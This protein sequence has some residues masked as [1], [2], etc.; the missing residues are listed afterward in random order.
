ML[1]GRSGW[2]TLDVFSFTTIVIAEFIA[3]QIVWLVCS[4]HPGPIFRPSARGLFAEL[5]APLLA[6]PGDQC[7]LDLV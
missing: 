2:T 3:R 4:F 5:L 7:V 6:T 1:T